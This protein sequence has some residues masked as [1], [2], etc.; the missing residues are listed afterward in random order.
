[1][2]FKTATGTARTKPETG[3]TPNPPPQPKNAPSGRFEP[4]P[5]ANFGPIRPAFGNTGMFKMDFPAPRNASC[6]PNR[7]SGE[8]LASIRWRRA[9]VRQSILL[10]ALLGLGGCNLMEF[11]PLGGN[12]SLAAETTA[13]EDLY[14]RLR[15]AQSQNAVLVQVIGDSTPLRVLPLPPDNR[16]IFVSQLLQQTGILDKFGAIEVTVYRTTPGMPGGVPME[17]RFNPKTGD[18]RP[19]CDYALRPGDRIRVAEADSA[20]ETFLDRFIPSSEG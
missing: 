15:E 5:V 7:P 9:A 14:R 8:P 16:S 2:S 4:S 18:I 10:A 11:R 3:L 12:G 20:F 6:P 19:E 13:T 1:L 17:V